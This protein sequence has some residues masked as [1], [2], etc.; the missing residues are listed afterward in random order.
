[1]HVLSVQRSR[2]WAVSRSLF[3]RSA[4]LS[5][6]N[7]IEV[8]DRPA[9]IFDGP[10]GRRACPKSVFLEAGKRSG[11]YRSLQ[12]LLVVENVIDIALSEL[13]KTVGKGLLWR[14][15]MYVQVFKCLTINIVTLIVTETK[16]PSKVRW[17]REGDDRA[18][19]K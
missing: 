1:M 16:L 4:T 17:D 6:I 5:S 2:R 12:L 9:R 3:L 7:G 18:G 19:S 15:E 11:P 13:L 10:A 14:R 8:I